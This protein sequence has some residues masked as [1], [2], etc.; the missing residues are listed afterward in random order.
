MREK[1]KSQ[2]QPQTSV[3]SDWKDRVATEMEKAA[4]VAGVFRNRI[5]SSALDSGVESPSD[6]QEDMFSREVD[7]QGWNLL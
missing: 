6:M 4:G 3:L 1:G 2:G 5:W 7:T